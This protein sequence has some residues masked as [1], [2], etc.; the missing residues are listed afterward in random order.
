MK[1]AISNIPEF[2]IPS[3]DFIKPILILSLHTAIIFALGRWLLSLADSSFTS[4]INWGDF[5]DVANHKEFYDIRLKETYDIHLGHIACIVY[6]TVITHF[7]YSYSDKWEIHIAWRIPLSILAGAG[8]SIFYFF[9][10]CL[11]SMSIVHF[12]G[13]LPIIGW[14]YIARS[15]F[16]LVTDSPIMA[17]WL[18]GLLIGG[19]TGSYLGYAKEYYE[20]YYSYDDDEWMKKWTAVWTSTL[21][22]VLFLGIIYWS[23]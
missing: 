1:K 5:W 7:Y 17:W 11:I 18:L 3:L 2:L 14:E 10:G 13:S 21:C 8:I 19:I 12:I 22:L 20:N 4:W 9:I 15:T 23:K 16:H 6:I